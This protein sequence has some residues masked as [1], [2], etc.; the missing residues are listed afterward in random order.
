MI[1]KKAAK[2][3]SIFFGCIIVFLIAAVY[4][5]N[6]ES[7]YVG[8]HKKTNGNTASIILIDG[9]DQTR[10]QN[11]LQKGKLPRL[12]NLINTGTYIKNGI[13]SFPSMTGYAFYPF[14]TGHDAVE[15][16]II[17]LRWFD[18]SLD[19]GNLRNYVGRTNV[20]M[21]Q[22][23][24]DTIKTFYQLSGDQYTASINSFM[25]KGVA[26]ARITGW[27]HTTAKFEGRSVIG[28]LRSIPFAGKE[29]AKNHYQH[30]SEVMRMAAGQLEQ[31][32]KV[33]WIALPSPDAT[34]HVDGMT[35]YYDNLLQY[36]DSLIGDFQVTID[37][38][39]QSDTRMLAIV[40]DHGIASV[41]NN[42]DFLKE[43][44][45]RMGLDLI[46]GNAVNYRSMQLKEPLSEFVEK[47]GYFVIN[48][49]LSAMLYLRDPS[50]SGTESWR[51]NLT[52]QQLID[53]SKNG[54]SVDIT[55][56]IA[57]MEGLEFVIFRKDKNTIIVKN[58]EGEASIETQGDRY[59][60]TSQSSNPFEYEIELIDT[61]LTANQWLEKTI[62]TDYPDAVY[63]LY[64]VMDMPNVGDFV[65][66]SKEGYDFAKDYEI[67]V[68]NYKG[69][70]GGIKANQ[71]RVP[72][73]LSVPNQDS[74]KIDHLRSED[75]GKMIGDWLG[76]SENY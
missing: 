25:N 9:L 49:N 29:L 45:E 58:K 55:D 31:N 13:G 27:T 21:N 39:G 64:S 59:K 23:I 41:E 11:A 37:E 5:V 34:F 1:L 63:R 20:W 30:E 68:G 35:D 32:P 70:H 52:S 22:D 18:R 4:F 53:F 62:N 65:L 10:F 14:I 17:G 28:P 61:F 56:G 33:Q 40:T 8:E 74:R 19:V 6:K 48:G 43:A 67:I 12:Q 54:T 60:Y 75:V 72:Y 2:Y 15:S 36:I 73:I 38:L 16:G 76:F 69:G 51:T 47:D 7:K 44:K 66:T 71:L 46:R 24:T 26:D 42:I 50:Q 3:L 57:N